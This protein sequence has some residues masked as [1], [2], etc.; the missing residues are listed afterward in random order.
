MLTIWWLLTRKNKLC[1]SDFIIIVV[2]IEVGAIH[3]IVCN[4][5]SI[6]FRLI[7]ICCTEVV[8]KYTCLCQVSEPVRET[9]LGAHAYRLF[10]ITLQ[11]LLRLFIFRSQRN[12]RREEPRWYTDLECNQAATRWFIGCRAGD[13]Q[14]EQLM[15]F[16]ESRAKNWGNDKSSA[17]FTPANLTRAV[18]RHT[19]PGRTEN[20][21]Q[22]YMQNFLQNSK[23][24]G[25]CSP[26]GEKLQSVFP[27][28]CPA[29]DAVIHHAACGDVFGDGV[30]DKA[31]LY[32]I[33]DNRGLHYDMLSKAEVREIVVGQTQVDELCDILQFYS[34]KATADGEDTPLVFTSLDCEEIRILEGDY[35]RVTSPSMPE[36]E[37]IKLRTVR[38]PGEKFRQLPVRIMIGN[39]ETWAVMVTI[40]VIVQDGDMYLGRIMFQ[41]GVP[42]FLA[43]LPTPV[44]VGTRSD[45]MEIEELVRRCT[46]KDF[47]MHDYVD[48][49]AWAVAAGW[50]L[51]V[52][53]MGAL[54]Y[55]LL[56]CVMNKKVSEG[57]GKWGLLWNQLSPEMQVYCLGDLKVG[58]QIALV[59]Y[60]IM[61]YN[62]F[63]DPDICL[64]LTRA[65]HSEFGTWFAKYLMSVLPGVE[66]RSQGI[67]GVKDIRELL[68]CLRYRYSDGRLSEGPPERV[69]T[70]L[71]L[72]GKWSHV[73]H[74]GAR[75]LH[76]VRHKFVQQHEVL[77]VAGA[78]H[79]VK[80]MYFPLTKEEFGAAVYG[81]ENVANLDYRR[82]TTNPMGLQIHPDLR[83]NSVTTKDLGRVTSE[84]VRAIAQ[85]TDA[86]RREMLYEAARIHY[87]SIPDFL[88]TVLA[89]DYFKTYLRSY[90]L[91][92]RNIFF[93]V[94]GGHCKVVDETR[95]VHELLKSKTLKFHEHEKDRIRVLEEEIEVRRAEIARRELRCEQ[96]CN[97]YDRYDD[98]S[99]PPLKVTFRG[100]LLPVGEPSMRPK[101]SM[102]DYEPVD[103]AGEFDSFVPGSP[104]S[105][106]FGPYKNADE[107]VPLGRAVR[108]TSGGTRSGGG[109]STLARD[110]VEEPDNRQR[111]RELDGFEM[112]TVGDSDDSD[113]G[114]VCIGE[115]DVLAR[116]SDDSDDGGVVMNVREESVER[117]LE[118]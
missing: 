80:S 44:G 37:L 49:H 36:D 50:N 4:T 53:T 117:L 22:E 20:W 10:R 9:R 66:V 91:E 88:K 48:L 72:Y 81:V 109:M 115:H 12:A 67:A 24:T 28:G 17:R 84:D 79:W 57:D 98:D 35:E 34:D 116:G 94:T 15:M 58:H 77:T 25:V 33:R 104:D 93:R 30:V 42:E 74:G 38:E 89:D 99:I 105:K 107:F 110:E 78:P 60:A 1:Q 92:P 43:A 6:V 114:V 63:P 85:D 41:K 97:E 64:Q 27:S 103:L 101:G 21:C 40:P 54:A 65:T 11:N 59:L 46:G 32:Q 16:E 61:V 2:F 68:H 118:D 51:P 70:L 23:L 71:K 95:E 73:M 96:L 113:D 7:Y 83:E 111:F 26:Y 87:Y 52:G 3:H 55:M 18:A 108:G 5:Q 112:V 29:V 39:G 13:V 19:P 82:R 90:Y 14:D 100:Q 8:M 76:F 106:R 75:Y 62:F 31:R 86:M 69:L 56:G 47:K 102:M 45:I